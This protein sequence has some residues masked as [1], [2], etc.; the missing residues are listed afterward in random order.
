MGSSI[1][2]PCQL[3]LTVNIVSCSSFC[4][5]SIKIGFSYIQT[6]DLL[7]DL[8]LFISICS[9]SISKRDVSKTNMP[10]D[11]LMFSTSQSMKW[12]F[13]LY[14]PDVQA[15][16]NC[17][18][19][20]FFNSHT[21]ATNTVICSLVFF[22]NC[23]TWLYSSMSYSLYT[24]LASLKILYIQYSNDETTHIQRDDLNHTIVLL[25]TDPSGLASQE[26]PVHL[27]WWLP[28]AKVYSKPRND[29]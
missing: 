9:V 3:L 5:C 25:F 12:N 10:W 1:T 16:G 27:Q 21:S 4:W 8:Y 6:A 18:K 17:F 22:Y 26:D 29:K 2:T 13:I 15:E 7:N 19:S 11:F 20:S 14:T 28:T 24:L 23:L